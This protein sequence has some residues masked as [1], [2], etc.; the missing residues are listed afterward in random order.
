MKNKTKLLI[1]ALVMVFITFT[2]QVQA[3]DGGGPLSGSV[4]DLTGKVDPYVIMIVAFV[5][6]QLLFNPIFR[7]SAP[8]EYTPPVVWLDDISSIAYPIIEDLEWVI[9][10]NASL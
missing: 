2:T 6:G 3:Q 1:M 7:P 8:E 10:L 5:I 4:F 9:G